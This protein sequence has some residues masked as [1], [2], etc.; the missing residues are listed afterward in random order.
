[1]DNLSRG[2]AQDTKTLEVYYK[3]CADFNKISDY[4]P[5]NLD[6]I[7]NFGFCIGKL[8]EMTNLRTLSE[9]QICSDAFDDLITKLMEIIDN[10]E[11]NMDFRKVCVEEYLMK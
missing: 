10:K 9:D 8:G 5:T 7:T 1:M 3:L 6:R 11:L 2:N 4:K